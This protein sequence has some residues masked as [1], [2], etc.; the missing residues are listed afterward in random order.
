MDPIVVALVG[1]QIAVFYVAWVLTQI[2]RHL[3]GKS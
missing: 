1:V 2:E 3:R